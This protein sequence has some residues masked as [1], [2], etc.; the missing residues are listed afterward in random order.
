MYVCIHTVKTAGQCV[1]LS[2]GT[3]TLKIWDQSQ[4]K[5]IVSR[6]GFRSSA[7]W[8]LMPKKH[9]NGLINQ[10]IRL[11]HLGFKL[12]ILCCF[13][14]VFVLHRSSGELQTSEEHGCAA[15]VPVDAP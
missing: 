7:T 5:S 10:Y 14:G 8:P 9:Y 4:E 2:Y 11:T 1:E 6:S 12:F 13:T 15:P 3:C